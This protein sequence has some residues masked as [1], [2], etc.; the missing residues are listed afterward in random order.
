MVV[1]TRLFSCGLSISH[2]EQRPAASP[3]CAAR[4]RGGR[5]ASGEPSV[6]QASIVQHSREVRSRSQANIAFPRSADLLIYS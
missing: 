2:V 5:P 3:Q 4:V 6:Q 1:Q